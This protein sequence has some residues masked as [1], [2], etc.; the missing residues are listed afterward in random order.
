MQNLLD[1]CMHLHF[2][3]CLLRSK[4]SEFQVYCAELAQSNVIGTSKL[5]KSLKTFL[6]KL[7]F[8][9]NPTMDPLN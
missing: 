7:L 1:N 5:G 2:Q 9:M 4:N 3:L 8:Y 6:L